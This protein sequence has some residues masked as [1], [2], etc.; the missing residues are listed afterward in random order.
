[1]CR[2]KIVDMKRFI[3]IILFMIS[4]SCYSQTMSVSSF[5]LLESDLDAN[6]AGTME[7]DQNGEVAALIKVVTN[8]TGFSFDGGS[9]GIWK[10]KQTPGEIWVYIPRGAKKITIKHP[11]FGVLRDYYFTCPIEAARTY[12]L[13][14]VTGSIQTIVNQDAG[15]QYLVMHVDPPTAIVYI[16]D[17]EVTLQNGSVSKFLSYGNHTY[18][19]NDPLYAADAGSFEIGQEKKVLDIKLQPSF[20]VLQL[21]TTPENGAKIFIDDD[22]ESVGLTPFTTKKIKS[23]QHRF[24]FQLSGY[25]SKT[26]THDVHSDGSTQSLVVPLTSN[27][28]S[29][30][31]NIADGC[32]LYID[33]EEKGIG[34]WKGRLAEG[35][36]RVEARK[37][38]HASVK[39]TIT[40][41]KGEDKVVSLA[42]PTPIYGGLNINSNP[43]GASI[44]IDDEKVGSTP[45][46]LNKVLIGS[47]SVR[48]EKEGFEPEVM[49]ISVE[50]G[51][52][53]EMSAELRIKEK[54][55]LTIVTNGAESKLNLTNTEL[56]EYAKNVYKNNRKDSKA[57]IE[58]ARAYFDHGNIEMATQYANY[59]NEVWKPKYSYAPA[60]LLLGDIEA[61]YGTDV[62]K[63][64]GYYNQAIIHDPKNPEGYKKWAMVYRKIN[65]SQAAK[66][67]DE[68]KANCPNEDVD[69]VK[70]HIYMLAGDEK[71]AYENYK[72]AD[73]TK[74]D[75]N[76]LNEFVRC[77]YFTGHFE[78]ALRAAETGIKLEP[79]NPT[80]NRL[81][82]FASYEVGK[83]DIA[84]KYLDKYFNETDNPVYN[85]YDHFYAA[86]IYQALGDRDNMYIQ[87][88]K[89]LAL[90]NDS[91]L[92]KRPPILKAVS[93][94][95]LKDQKFDNAIKY[96]EQFLACKPDL[97]VDDYDGLASIYS[98]YADADESR[99]PELIG[100]AIKVYQTIGEKY[101]KQAI[102]ANYMLASKYNKLDKSGK[103][104]LAKPYYQKVVNLLEKKTDRSKSENLMLKT[105]YHYLMNQALL[106]A[107]DK[108]KAKEFANKIL[109]IDPD[110]GAAQKVRDL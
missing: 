17:N 27:Y 71:Q 67:L 51:K 33:N 66:K 74:L 75:K 81:A 78:D 93:D 3:G 84:K 19:I 79:R 70:G 48:F 41:E 45:E 20:G 53:Q 50:E 80:F 101:P 15:G 57:L 26:I 104:G 54:K 103:K 108:T 91:S 73:I 107:N 59:A 64:A 44:Y 86:L 29:V 62:G 97:T 76:G 83:Y 32:T 40:V 65:P 61:S 46:I 89:S 31:I 49:Q 38:G 18:R 21:S 99:A 110:Y 52:I 47:H 72:K 98:K 5:R 2:F 23:G 9:L 7:R 92:I 69:A 95:Y 94:S 82:M 30:T 60:Y 16:D 39:E 28:A 105:S 42:T 11:Q 100:K 102:Y 22:T 63:A 1:M 4:L 109:T 36:Y 56:D 87:F 77:S 10:V 43:I 24:R 85:E 14:L 55:E 68:M 34:N 106:Q 12:E 37:P 8:Q 13:V 90:L 35:L 58:V 88:D 6:T 25:D 96:Y